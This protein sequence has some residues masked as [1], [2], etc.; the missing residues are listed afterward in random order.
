[1]PITSQWSIELFHN[2]TLID[3]DFSCSDLFS[4]PNARQI[5]RCFKSLW[6][7]SATLRHLS[8][9]L[10]RIKPSIER[11]LIMSTLGV[12]RHLI[13]LLPNTTHSLY[14]TVITPWPAVLKRNLTK[15]SILMAKQVWIMALSRTAKAN[16]LTMISVSTRK[17]RAMATATA[18]EMFLVGIVRLV[19]IECWQCHRKCP[20]RCAIVLETT[21]VDSTIMMLYMTLQVDAQPHVHL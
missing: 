3:L 4:F 14:A 17:S 20:S 2:W 9:R 19:R 1:M 16:H 7:E 11:G 18:I 12:K 6:F 13:C 5:D 21:A 10:R 15:C 8:Q